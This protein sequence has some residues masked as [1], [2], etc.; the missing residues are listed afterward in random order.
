MFGK[1]MHRSCLVVTLPTS[2]T[3]RS[4]LDHSA[5]LAERIDVQD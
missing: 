4:S 2:C 3:Q 5:D 1:A